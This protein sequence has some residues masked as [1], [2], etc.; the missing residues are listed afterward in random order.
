MSCFICNT[1][2]IPSLSEMPT[3]DFLTSFRLKLH[4]YRLCKG[5]A[6][7]LGTSVFLGHFFKNFATTDGSYATYFG[8]NCSQVSVPPQCLSMMSCVI[9]GQV[10][11][12]ALLYLKKLVL[13][14]KFFSSVA[15]S[16][17]N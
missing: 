9:R 5:I 13:I 14:L 16:K 2:V 12:L 4:G 15:W 3:L 7:L 17:L 8:S 10:A 6:D 1:N 11:G